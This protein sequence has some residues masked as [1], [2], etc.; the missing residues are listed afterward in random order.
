MQ[1][2]GAL[3]RRQVL[4]VANKTGLD[5]K[6]LLADMKTHEA[7]FKNIIQKN[8]ELAKSLNITGT[9]AFVV[10]GVIVRGAVDYQSLKELVKA[11]RIANR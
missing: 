1:A 10:G 7:K 9:P 4:K 5:R 3:T 6:K 11:T 2:K 8:L